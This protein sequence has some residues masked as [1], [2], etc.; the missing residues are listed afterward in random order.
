MIFITSALQPPN[1]PD[2]N[3]ID[4]TACSVLQEW[5]YRTKISDVDEL[6]RRIISEWATWVTRLLTV[7]LKSGVSVYALAFV[8]EADI[9]NTRWNKVCVMWHVPQ[10]LFWETITVSHVCCNSVNHSS[11]AKCTLNYCVNSSILHFKF[12]KVVQAHTL[13]EVDILGTVL[14]RV[15]SGTILTFFIEIGS[16]LTDREQK[17]SRHSFFWDTVY[18][19]HRHTDNL[20]QTQLDVVSTSLVNTK[21]LDWKFSGNLYLYDTVIQTLAV[22]NRCHRSSVR[23]KIIPVIISLILLITVVKCIRYSSN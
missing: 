18:I 9:L 14:L 8:L 3:A 7:L 22:I 17:I 12:P 1:S 2:L 6:K 21:I 23:L 5:V 11:G 20:T 4:Y 15:S 13:G 10:W 19:C 16:Y